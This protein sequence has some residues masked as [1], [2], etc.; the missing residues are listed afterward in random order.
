MRQL[1]WVE[2]RWKLRAL[3]SHTFI[4]IS[5]NLIISWIVECAKS[6][7]VTKAQSLPSYKLTI[8]QTYYSIHHGPL[9]MPVSSIARWPVNCLLCN[10]SVNKYSIIRH[11]YHHHR[12]SQGFSMT[13]KVWF[14]QCAV[15]ATAGCIVFKL[16]GTSDYMLQI[17]FLQ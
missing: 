13:I 3:T 17:D 12:I 15:L 4:S 2:I 1:R 6:V 16:G 8:T 11:L 10:V 9:L 14:G 7:E 5:S